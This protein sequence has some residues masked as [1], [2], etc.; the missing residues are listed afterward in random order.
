MEVSSVL[1]ALLERE[2]GLREPRVAQRV[3]NQLRQGLPP[4]DGILAL[5]PN[6]PKI[7][8][9]VGR[10][11]EQRGA[12]W[13]PRRNIEPVNVFV[14]GQPGEGKT[15]LM[16]YVEAAQRGLGAAAA[17]L[18]T[19]QFGGRLDRPAEWLHMLL[20]AMRVPVD[21]RHVRL[22]EALGEWRS[23]LAE[24]L[25]EWVS[26]RARSV[27]ASELAA[28]LGAFLRW[29]GERDL[30]RLLG[31][32]IP[33]SRTT[34]Y[35]RRALDR[36]AAW[37]DLLQALG[38]PRL[39]LLIDQLETM[40]RLVR[41]IRSRVKIYAFWHD[42]FSKRLPQTVVLWSVVPDQFTVLESDLT[43]GRLE[44]YVDSY[45]HLRPF[46]RGFRDAPWPSTEVDRLSVDECVLH[47]CN[48]IALFLHA[49]RRLGD[50]RARE[51]A[52][53][54]AELAATIRRYRDDDPT[55]RHTTT[56]LVQWL[57]QKFDC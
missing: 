51:F 34:H 14:R 5:T 6:G 24:V 8:A 26:R 39:V 38:I 35:Q 11:F 40:E 52:R 4:S 13:R 17:W 15:H 29:G 10:L 31:V 54:E 50:P 48:V 22:V 37:A 2:P 23:S 32:G 21:G 46:V 53:C 18:T 47:A 16:R 12:S 33:K 36:L 9:A 27:H 45:D 55:M 3:L 25:R 57:S 49:N 41:D 56:A 42:P 19:E 28:D 43:G 44:S 1:Q 20:D 7:E 30:G